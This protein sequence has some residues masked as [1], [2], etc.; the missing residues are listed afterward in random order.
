MSMAHSLEA[1]VP[2]LDHP[3]VE[4]AA[5]TP[6]S[7]HIR[8]GITKYLLKR[9]MQGTLPQAILDRPK[10]GFAVPLGRWFRGRLGEVAR[11]VLCCATARSRGVLCE[12]S[13][14]RMLD[15]PRRGSA[16]DLRTW[17]LLSFELWCRRFLDA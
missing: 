11:D 17:T 13:V 6:P 5:R 3:V 1:R 9:S 12:R 8:G 2:F 10:Q 7:L 14:L 15:N 4:L 16:L